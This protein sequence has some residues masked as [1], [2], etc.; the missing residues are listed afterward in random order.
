RS[1]RVS[2][3]EQLLD[4]GRSH[5]GT[6]A[7][8]SGRRLPGIRAPT[9]AWYGG[10]GAHG[11]ADDPSAPASSV[12]RDEPRSADR[13]GRQRAR[14][15]RPERAVGVWVALG[16]GVLRAVDRVRERV[17][18]YTRADHWPGARARHANRP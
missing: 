16:G 10:T 14:S 6:R 15:R 18:P 11:T 1:L 2:A 13:R 9:P 8:R 3:P 5:A 4:D 17:Q 12:S 7:A